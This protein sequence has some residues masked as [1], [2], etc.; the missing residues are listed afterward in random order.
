MIP[1]CLRTEIWIP[2][3]LGIPST[4]PCVAGPT[5]DNPA[6]AK[7]AW[8]TAAMAAWGKG[9]YRLEMVPKLPPPPEIQK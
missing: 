5:S 7:A 1:T 8:G 6:T 3:L 9:N 4:S 2:F